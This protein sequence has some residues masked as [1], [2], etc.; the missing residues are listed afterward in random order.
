LGARGESS[1]T[2]DEG[3][4]L[5]RRRDDLMAHLERLVD[6]WQAGYLTEAEFAAAKGRILFR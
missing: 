1:R 3:Q 2:V 4:D 5:E 6:M